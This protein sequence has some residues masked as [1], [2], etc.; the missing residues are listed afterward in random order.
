M[1]RFVYI[2]ALAFLS[3]T[4][5]FAH[6]T[7]PEVYPSLSDIPDPL[8]ELSRNGD[9]YREQYVSKMLAP[10]RNY[11]RD[12]NVLDAQDVKQL[13]NRYLNDWR[14]R[15]A[16]EFISYDRNFDGKFTRE[17]ITEYY[18]GTSNYQREVNQFDLEAEINPKM[19]ADGN[20]DGTITMQETINYADKTI[21]MDNEEDLNQVKGLVALDASG[22]N[23]ISVDEVEELARKA[24]LTMDT[25]GNGIITKDESQ[26]VFKVK[27]DRVNANHMRE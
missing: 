14:R 7:K 13:E 24:F 9:E 25:D 8:L 22:N 17:E 26:A 16:K 21:K 20:G 6:E 27:L 19:L 10:I 12:K 23:R 3:A 5:A 4:T 2:A 1:K 18:L 11:G 15:H